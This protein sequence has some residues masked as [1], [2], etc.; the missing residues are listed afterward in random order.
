MKK[1]LKGLMA[2]VLLTAALVILP[3]LPF[4]WLN[5]RRKK[6]LDARKTF[7][8]GNISEAVFYIFQH[9]IAWLEATG[10]G[11]GNAPYAVWRVGL[12]PDYAERFAACEKLF[13][14]AAY[15]NH[16]MKEEDRQQALALLNET[17]HLL[18]RQ[19][20]WKQ[21]LRLKYKECLWV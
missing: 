17:E 20:D 21:R 9:V 4:L 14:E 2:A 1:H 11:E 12:S 10:H 16:E 18:Q 13:E 8:S 7:E 15:S 5:Q 19:A 6:A 3:F